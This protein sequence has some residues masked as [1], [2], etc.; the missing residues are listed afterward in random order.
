VTN[1]SDV[2]SAREFVKSVTLPEAPP[3][4]F[5]IAKATPTPFETA[6]EQ[7]SVVGSDVIAF[8]KGVTPETRG[9]I[10]NA[11]L[12]A[13]LVA[14]KSM[15]EPQTLA[16]VGAWYESYFDTLSRT[17]FV[18]QDKGFAEYHAKSDTFEAH[19]AIIEVA[20]ALLAGS[21]GALAL[22]KTTLGALKKVSADS[23]WITLFHRES[24]SA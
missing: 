3:V 18:I 4:R 13:Q 2:Q 17:G 15:A 12:L 7:A 14:K 24:Q 1:Q 19:E 23:P 6:K 11:V 16:E 5:D 21:P 20:T 22:V 9:D 8:A 10:V